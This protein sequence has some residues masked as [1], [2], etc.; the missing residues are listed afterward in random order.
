MPPNYRQDEP[1]RAHERKGVLALVAVVALTGAAI[2]S[3]ELATGGCGSKEGGKCVTVTVASATGGGQVRHC[4]HDA[5]TWCA[6]ETASTGELASLARAACRRAGLL[7]GPKTQPAPAPVSG[8][9]NRP[10]RRS[11][12]LAPARHG[13]AAGETGPIAGATRAEHRLVTGETGPVGG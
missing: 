12:D 3:W 9:R 8:G 5:R 4:G 2:G 7:A 11:G 1:L 10:G 6:S 13:L